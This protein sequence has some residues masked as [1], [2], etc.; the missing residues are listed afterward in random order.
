M[1]D[2]TPQS[3]INKTHLEL[4]KNISPKELQVFSDSDSEV[5]KSNKSIIIEEEAIT[6]I[7][8]ETHIYKTQKYPSIF[9]LIIKQ[10]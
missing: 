3:I 5:I 10:F 2:S 1:Y 7:K 9:L 4:H 8:G 6:D